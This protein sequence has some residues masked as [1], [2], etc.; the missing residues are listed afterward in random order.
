MKAQSSIEAALVITFMLFV[1]TAFMGVMAKRG[2]DVKRQSEMASLD[3][4]ANLLKYEV[5]EAQKSEDGYSRVFEVPDVI[6]GIPFNISIINS[7][8]LNSSNPD[9]FELVINATK[10]RK[11]LIQYYTI[12]GNVS[13]KLCQKTLIRKFNKSIRFLCVE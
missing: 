7:T 3:N 12:R 11:N 1:L 13:G 8:A 10:Y 4:V 9:S 2:I 6:D 5:L